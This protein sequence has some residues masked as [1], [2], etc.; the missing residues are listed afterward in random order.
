MHAG[1]VV[2]KRIGEHEV[3]IEG[4]VLELSEEYGKVLR[5][6]TADTK[7]AEAVRARLK[8]GCRIQ[9]GQVGLVQRDED[10]HVATITQQNGL[11]EHWD[12]VSGEQFDGDMVDKARKEELEEFK[13]HQVYEKVPIKECWDNTGKAPIGTRWIDINK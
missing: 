10:N 5:V 12:D 3:K 7:V 6:K 11:T 4:N 9:L 8:R 13:K 1:A 2:V